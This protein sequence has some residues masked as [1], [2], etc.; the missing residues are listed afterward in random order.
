[1]VDP[2][3]MFDAFAESARTLQTWHDSGRSGPRPPGRLRPYA[4]DRLSRRTLVWATPLYRTVY[5]PDGRPAPLK[6]RNRY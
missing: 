1:M 5:D 2:V 6:R 4:L 3:A